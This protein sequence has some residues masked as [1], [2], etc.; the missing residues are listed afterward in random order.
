MKQLQVKNS[1]EWRKWLSLNHNKVDGVWLV[2]LKGKE[3]MNS[4]D[5][6]KAVE[7]ALC[8]GWIDSIIKKLDEEKYVRKFTPR[9][10]KSRWSDLNKSR[11]KKLIKE[12]KMTP[13]GLAKIEAAKKNG[14]WNKPIESYADFELPKEFK[15]ALRKNA[16]AENFFN[17]L[18]P[19]YKKYFIGWIST[20]KKEETRAARIKES[21][22]LLSAGKK[23]GMK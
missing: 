16:K 13:V 19:S 22:K 9:K 8:Y 17:S 14:F 5:Y 2:F 12:K 3:K 1:V 15:T 18:A 21:V 7:D 4:L 20:A 11:V 6:E 10:D 23:L